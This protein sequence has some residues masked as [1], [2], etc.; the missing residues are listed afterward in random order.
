ML[1]KSVGL[2]LMTEVAFAGVGYMEQVAK[3]SGSGRATLFE[4]SDTA[5]GVVQPKVDS[6]FNKFTIFQYSGLFAGHSY[7]TGSRIRGSRS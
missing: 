4:L 1:K 6:L 7:S 2:N 3:S 5:Q